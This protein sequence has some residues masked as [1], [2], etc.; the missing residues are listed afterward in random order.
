[1][2]RTSRPIRGSVRPDQSLRKP[3]FT[4]DPERPQAQHQAQSQSP[5][6]PMNAKRPAS[7]LP[8]TYAH[9][10]PLLRR[11]LPESIGPSKMDTSATV[12]HP[13]TANT[14]TA[15]TED[16][17]SI[18]SGSDDPL[19]LAPKP[20]K[21]Q[22]HQQSA[23]PLPSIHSSKP[24][25]SSDVPRPSPPQAPSPG[26]AH[27][28]SQIAHLTTQKSTLTTTL[29]TLTSQL[30]P[31]AVDQ[32]HPDG[33]NQEQSRHTLPEVT[34]QKHIKLLHRYN[35]TK[36]V[37]MGLMGLIAESRGVRL[38]EVLSEFGAEGDKG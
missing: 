25:A 19:P 11:R 26:T 24:E 8:S 15:D 5:E 16:M 17:A 32:N 30:R 37:A 7:D 12:I 28:Q 10:I 34:V 6:L 29:A 23:S 31:L 13:V 20:Q 1:M 14:T 9:T 36:D 27:L 4:E 18:N 21:V 38:K 22:A 3:E 2:A 33:Q 35:E